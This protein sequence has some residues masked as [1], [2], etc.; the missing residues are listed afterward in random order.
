MRARLDVVADARALLG[1]AQNCCASGFDDTP[2]APRIAAQLLAHPGTRGVAGQRD[3]QSVDVDSLDLVRPRSVGVEQ[4]G[5]WALS[6][7]GLVERLAE[8][9]GGDYRQ[10]I[11]LEFFQVLLETSFPDRPVKA[12]R[13]NSP[14]RNA[15][16][17]PDIVAASASACRTHATPPVSERGRV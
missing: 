17:R 9:L 13:H 7:L 16:M 6:Q 4:V 11:G 1:D 2:P 5:L 15:A 14:K 12:K 8:L 3:L 10:A